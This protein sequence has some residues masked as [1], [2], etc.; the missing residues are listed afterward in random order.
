ML[1]F[2]LMVN[3]FQ[4]SYK[5]AVLGFT[6]KM[7]D[8]VRKSRT[9]VQH[10]VLDRNCYPS[11]S[12]DDSN[13]FW[14]YGIEGLATRVSIANMFQRSSQTQRGCGSPGCILYA[15]LPAGKK[16]NAT[17]APPLT[18]DN[19]ESLAPDS[20]TPLPATLASLLAQPSHQAAQRNWSLHRDEHDTVPHTP[21]RCPCTR[22]WYWSSGSL[23]TGDRLCCGD[24]SF[25]PIRRWLPILPWALHARTCKGLRRW[26][27]QGRT[28]CWVWLL[29]PCQGC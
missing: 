15:I 28:L 9:E 5:I 12:I 7:I 18:W 26:D 3:R 11:H 10:F 21:P 14:K 22:L 29:E 4:I 6:S 1:R 20:S 13:F 8:L 16:N 27:F 2:R 19:D 24:T 25:R 17:K 23:V